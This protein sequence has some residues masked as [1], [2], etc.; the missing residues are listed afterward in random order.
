MAALFTHLSRPPKALD[1]RRDAHVT[2]VR[3]DA[4]ETTGDTLLNR[5]PIMW[6]VDNDRYQVWRLEHEL[7]P[8]KV[9][10]LLNSITTADREPRFR[11]TIAPLGTAFRGLFKLLCGV[12]AALHLARRRGGDLKARTKA[13]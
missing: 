7:A 3:E 12:P 2:P 5:R 8:K 13:A 9:D 4:G 10:R 11:V 6:Q 1:R